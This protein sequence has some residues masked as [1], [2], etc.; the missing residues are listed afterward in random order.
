MAY[1]FNPQSPQYK[2]I[3][4]RYGLLRG[5]MYNKTIFPKPQHIAGRLTFQN[6]THES[7]HINTGK[8]L[9]EREYGEFYYRMI[10]SKTLYNF[11]I[12]TG[13]KSEKFYIFNGYDYEV[14]VS[15]VTLNGLTGI[16]IVPEKGGYPISIPPYRSRYMRIQLS[17]NGSAVLNGSFTLHFSN[18]DSLTMHIKGSRL[19]LWN[20]PPNWNEPLSEQFEYKTDIITSYNKKEQRRGFLT[21]PRRK[22]TYTS[23]PHDGLIM[24]LRNLLYGW[25]DKVFM[26]PLWWQ[27]AKLARRAVTGATELHLSGF[28]DFDFVQNGSMV[29]WKSPEYNEVL[30]IDNIT[31]G[32][33]RLG[34]QLNLPF[35]EGA[36]VYPAVIVRISPEMILQ[37]V[38]SSVGVVE[39]EANVVQQSLKFRMPEKQAT[40]TFNGIEILDKKPNWAD[41]VSETYN[42]TIDELDFGYGVRDYILRDVPSLMQKEMNFVA[43]SY[44][45]ILWWKA[46]IQRQKGALKSFLVPT[47]TIDAKLE[48][49][50]LKGQSTFQF[51]DDYFST[52][53]RYT[54]DKQYLRVKYGEMVYYFTIIGVKNE[55][56][57][58][59]VEIKEPVPET[60]F[61][62]KVESISYLQ[63]MRFAGDA[64]QIEY[65]TRTVA[66]ISLT[67]QQVREV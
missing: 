17:A 36:T 19:I 40:T 21:Q 58:A 45:E 22:I 10:P 56:N 63:R 37:V 67:L 26:M 18:G 34:A 39:I 3:S 16:E 51:R 6:H 11:G 2:T 4:K 44:S 30:E 53:V 46:F 14:H 61:A 8:Y 50:V 25:Q 60:I 31:N 28:E 42:A 43:K 65:I 55:D 23:A 27:P 64:V 48:N 66:N 1:L 47:H 12:I 59:I 5:Q 13:D 32:V 49:D 41:D 33:V 15:S 57:R 62:S 29:L 54:K 24:Q 52:V 35:E 38:T 9:L 20:F 7:Y